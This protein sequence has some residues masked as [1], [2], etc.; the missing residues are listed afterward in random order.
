[1]PG[2]LDWSRRPSARSP[3]L[4]AP[5]HPPRAPR[6][7]PRRRAAGLTLVE[8]LAGMA[9]VALLLQAAV[10]GLQGFLQRRRLL[11]Q[12]AALQADLQWLRT[13][14]VA[15]HQVLRITWQA[16][17]AGACQMLH[18]GDAGDCRCEADTPPA[19]RVTCA[20][21]ARLLQAALPADAPQVRLASNVTTMRVDPRHGTFTPTGSIDLIDAG[22]GATLRHAV[23]IL[24]RVRL[25]SPGRTVHGVP[26][27]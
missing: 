24:G 18:S 14:A 4:H 26:A 12:S 19:P 3:S 25:C 2:C 11:G 17:P 23:S 20:T 8:W 6:H 1:M 21:G 16:T 10:P 13:E 22:S 15:R 7:G 27:C 9:V 5:A